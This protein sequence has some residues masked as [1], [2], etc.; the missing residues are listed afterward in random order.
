MNALRMI[1]RC[2]KHQTDA[3]RAATCT[4]LS[5]VYSS[6]PSWAPEGEFRP[7]EAMGNGET[8]ACGD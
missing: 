1:T 6:E 7:E 2:A 5:A 4:E 3:A 8:V